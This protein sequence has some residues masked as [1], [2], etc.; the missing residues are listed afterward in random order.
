MDLFESLRNGDE[1]AFT[2]LYNKYNPGLCSYAYR[3]LGD[4]DEAKE[5]VHLF[6]CHLWDTHKTLDINTSLKSYLYKSVYNRC[7]SL[8]RKKRQYQKYFKLGLGDLLFSRIIQ[9]PFTELKLIDSESRKVILEAL[10]ELPPRR[11]EIFVKCKIKGMTYAQVADNLN[12]STKTVEAQMTQALKTLRL[13]LDWLL[14]LLI[15]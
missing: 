6:F 10:K 3:I 2:L 1:T 13:K 15:V 4:N 14:I 12:I 8:L 11:R 9:D 5:I 7:I